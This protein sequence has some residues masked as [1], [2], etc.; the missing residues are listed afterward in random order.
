[1]FDG[2]GQSVFFNVSVRNFLFDGFEI[3]N[4]KNFAKAGDDM[5]SVK[6]VCSQFKSNPDAA[7]S[8]KMTKD[9]AFFAFLYKVRSVNWI[10]FLYFTHSYI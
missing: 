5:F 7:K 1:M 2:Y 4:T 3:C 10:A 6:V 8:M 9:A